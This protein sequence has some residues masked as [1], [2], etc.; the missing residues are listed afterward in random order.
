MFYSIWF[1]K[2]PFQ[3]SNLAISTKMFKD[4]PLNKT[5][6]NLIN[7]PTVAYRNNILNLITIIKNSGITPIF[8]QFYQPTFRDL[9]ENNPSAFL[10]TSR[11]LGD[12][13]MEL[14]EALYAGRMRLKSEAQKLCET[15]DVIFWD[16]NRDNLP[17]KYFC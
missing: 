1:N 11:I 7:N 17:E 2:I 3:K 4:L 6:S 9:K 12:Q 15:E 14:N 13:L 10:N 8:F 5:Q 16:I